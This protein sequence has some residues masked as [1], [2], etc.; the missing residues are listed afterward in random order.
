[1]ALVTEIMDHALDLPRADRSYLA[2]K[3]IESLDVERALSAEW[4]DEIEKRVARR[5]AG[6]THSITSEQVHLDI[7][8]LLAR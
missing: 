4:M 8:N 1:M 3:L 5:K 2:K 7:E 6:E